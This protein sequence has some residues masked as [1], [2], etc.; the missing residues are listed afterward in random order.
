[1]KLILSNEENALFPIRELSEITQVN[2]VTLRAWERRYGL[3]K[4]Q[5]TAKGHRLYS[6]QDVS[7][8]KAILASIAKGVP[9]GKVKALLAES[10]DQQHSENSNDWYLLI[11]QLESVVQSHSLAK[12]KD[13]LRDSFLNYPVDLVRKEIIAPVMEKLESSD[14]NLA[15]MALF[16]S[17]VID[18][19]M[20]RLNTKSSK[21]NQLPIMLI[22]AQN[23]PMWK[24]ALSAIELNDAGYKVTLINQPCQLS[25]WIALAKQACEIPCVV[26]QEGV[27]RAEDSLNIK[28]FSAQQDNLFLCGTAATLAG[29]DSLKNVP[30]PESILH[31]LTK[32]QPND[33]MAF[34]KE[35]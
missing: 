15:A 26:F 33:E 14:N 17:A 32:D 25:S 35:K 9:V 30:N 1:M 5:R 19:T 29:I 20:V 28:A 23:S 13:F 22:C 34:N 7:R 31:F 16:Q 21:K 4:P 10:S 27:W 18:Y 8:V 24:L 6:Q 3:L 2:T 12:M 11:Q